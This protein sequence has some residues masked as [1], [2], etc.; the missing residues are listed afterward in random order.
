ML[1]VP[2][3][4]D[5]IVSMRHLPTHLVVAMNWRKPPAQNC[6]HLVNNSTDGAKISVPERRDRATHRCYPYHQSW[7]ILFGWETYQ[8]RP[9]HELMQIPTPST[10]GSWQYD[11]HVLWTFRQRSLQGWAFVV[12][13]ISVV[14]Q[15]KDQMR[16]MITWRCCRIGLS[17][18]GHLRLTLQMMQTS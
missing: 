4:D 17:L 5:S 6:Q 10:A 3:R 18:F 2:S 16:D 12:I 13:T 15:K 9:R 11:T 7:F 8:S 14:R 1:S